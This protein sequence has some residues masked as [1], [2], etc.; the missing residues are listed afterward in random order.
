[1][2]C[3]GLGV[4]SLIHGIFVKAFLPVKWFEIVHMKEEK[5]SDEEEKEAFTSSFRKSFR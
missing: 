3:L 5:M 2:I 4:F 1:L